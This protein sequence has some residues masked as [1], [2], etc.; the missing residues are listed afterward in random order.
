MIAP[1]WNRSEKNVPGSAKSLPQ[2]GRS[3][4]GMFFEGVWIVGY[5]PLMERTFSVSPIFAA[6]ASSNG[7][8]RVS[9]ARVSAIVST[10]LHA[11][12]VHF[13]VLPGSYLDCFIS[14]AALDT[15]PA[16]FAVSYGSYSAR[17]L[18]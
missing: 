11:E 17:P 9:T 15:S 12:A 10:P 18:L 3:E 16:L 1:E 14:A 6:S 13:P 7:T 8:M 5:A 4:N 2:E